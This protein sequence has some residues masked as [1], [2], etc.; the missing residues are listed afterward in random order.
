M[1]GFQ[2]VGVMDILLRVGLTIC[3]I[4]SKFAMCVEGT[5]FETLY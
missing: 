2:G 5:G 1:M 3:H 4:L